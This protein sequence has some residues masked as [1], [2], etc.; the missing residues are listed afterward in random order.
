[1]ETRGISQLAASNGA[2]LKNQLERVAKKHSDKVREVRGKGMLIGVEIDPKYDG[3][4]VSMNMLKNGVYAKETHETNLRIAPPIVI[5][6]DGIDKIASAL[7]KSL[8]EV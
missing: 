7:D 6:K 8:A 5:D 3:H 1:M 2:Y 4:R